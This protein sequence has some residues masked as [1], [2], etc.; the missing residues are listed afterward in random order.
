MRQDILCADLPPLPAR[1]GGCREML[2]TRFC[3]RFGIDAPIMVA[4]MGPDLTGPELVATVCNAGGFGVLQAQLCPLDLLR[5]QIRNL[6][7]LT[8]RPFGVN[9]VLQFP[10]E[11]GIQV[12]IDEQVVA[13][14]VFWG[15]PS[16]FVPAAHAAGIAVLHQ[17]GSVGAAV[18]ANQ[19]GVDVII[20]QGVE[21]GGHV[22]GQVSTMVLLPCIVDSVAPALVLAA[23]GIADARGLAAA[24][25][26]GADGVVMGT[27]FLATP[28]A[29]AHPIYKARVVAASEQDSVR[30]ILFG[31]GWPHAPHRTSRTPFVSDSLDRESEAQN[32][33]PDE[34]IVGHTVIAGAEMPVQRF[35][36]LPP[37]VHATGN[38]ESTALL[39]GQSV[40]LVDAIRAAAD[41][42]RETVD[43][44]ER[45]ICELSAK[46]DQDSQT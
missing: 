1:A 34:P 41:I 33:R 2:K 37:N 14:S 27:R 36:S 12:C 24:L 3:E 23:G 42:L 18:R 39:A 31:H 30:T 6:R 11:A 9:F 16:E 32:S 22:A 44:A 46:V 13:L 8:T 28:E 15:D 10:H 29:N 4:P 25:C 38:V 35:V 40:G 26:L 21:A 43:G 19:A 17:V 45:L 5:Q 20:A 7:T